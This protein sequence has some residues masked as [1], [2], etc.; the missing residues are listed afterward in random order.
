MA[1]ADFVRAVADALNSGSLHRFLD[2]V[3]D[4]FELDWSRSRGLGMGVYRGREALEAFIRAFEEVWEVASWDER[5]IEELSPQHVL[6]LYDLHFKGRG[7]G[8]EMRRPAVQL[9]TFDDGVPVRAAI[10]QSEE[11]ARAAAGQSSG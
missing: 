10:F 8:I 3:P 2:V 9:W 11:E 5:R 4:D 6:F 1:N 7:S